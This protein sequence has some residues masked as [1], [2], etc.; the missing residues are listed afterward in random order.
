M[1]EIPKTQIPKTQIHWTIRAK[2][3]LS[4]RAVARAVKAALE[5]GRRAGAELSVVFADDSTLRGLHGRTTDVISY[6]LGEEG[7]GP[8][9]ELYVSVERAHTVAEKRGVSVERELTLYVVHG[10]LHLCGFDDRTKR[11]RERMR[12]AEGR[13]LA[14][15]GFPPDLA[16][17]DL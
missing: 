3:V 13:V 4:N 15:L 7:G 9:G 10:V 11:D 2:R 12:A 1:T 14:G 17:H 16:P 6:D 5:H 8:A